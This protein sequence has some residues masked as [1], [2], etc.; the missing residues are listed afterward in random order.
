VNAFIFLL[1]HDGYIAGGIEVG[2]GFYLQHENC[3]IIFCAILQ[4]SLW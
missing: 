3:L 1:E 4:E 2:D